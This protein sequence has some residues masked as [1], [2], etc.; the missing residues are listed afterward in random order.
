MIDHHRHALIVALGGAI[1]V[2]LTL[3]VERLWSLFCRVS[4]AVKRGHVREPVPASQRRRSGDT[5]SSARIRGAAG[6]NI[7]LILTLPHAGRALLM[8]ARRCAPY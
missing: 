5:V 1:G 3:C 6:I 4:P 8:P 7:L 2:A